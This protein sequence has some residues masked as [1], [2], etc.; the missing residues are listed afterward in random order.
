MLQFRRAFVGRRAWRHGKFA[1]DEE[2]PLLDPL[3]AQL[4]KGKKSLQGIERAPESVHSTKQQRQKQREADFRAQS[5]CDSV[6]FEAKRQFQAMPL[7]SI[8]KSSGRIHV[9]GALFR[10]SAS[11]LRCYQPLRRPRR[12]AALEGPKIAATRERSNGR[13]DLTLSPISIARSRPRDEF[14]P[15]LSETASPGRHFVDDS[16]NAASWARAVS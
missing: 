16:I 1:H 15:R 14:L 13:W 2:S 11:Y 5:L 4:R 9:L 10:R 8:P 6:S 12:T 3:T 7:D